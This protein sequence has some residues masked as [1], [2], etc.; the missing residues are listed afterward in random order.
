L[1]ELPANPRLFVA[2][3]LPSE[4][5][6]TLNRLQ[7]ELQRYVP[8]GLRWVRPEGIH[9]TLKF[10]GETPRDRVPAIESAIGGGLQGVGK[11]E[12]SLAEMGTFGSRNSPRVL[13]VDLQG[14]SSTLLRLQ[15]QVDRALDAIGY[16]SE[17]RPFSP[18]LTLARVK[19]EAGR[20]V[21]EPLAE[22]VRSVNVPAAAIPVREVSLMLSKLGPGGAVYRR[23][24]AWPL[25]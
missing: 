15:K 11:H 25:G 18:H 5:L 13:W 21:A 20:E 6:A 3:E 9:L 16:P 19:P 22:A 17:K 8:G 10:L 2:V 12:L 23:L 4:A 14:D 7:H 24:E 1:E